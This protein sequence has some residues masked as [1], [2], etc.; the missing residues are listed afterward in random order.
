M[1]LRDQTTITYNQA[2]DAPEEFLRRWL[3]WALKGDPA[4]ERI[5]RENMGDKQAILAALVWMGAIG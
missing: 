3:A 5:T 4:E 2:Q 1:L